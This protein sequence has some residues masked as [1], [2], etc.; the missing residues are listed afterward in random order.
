[1]VTSRRDPTERSPSCGVLAT[2]TKH[3]GS[4]VSAPVR[5]FENILRPKKSANWSRTQIKA[6]R[7]RCAKSW[8]LSSP[9]LPASLG[10]NYCIKFCFERSH[11]KGSAA[12]SLRYKLWVWPVIWS[13]TCPRRRS[14]P[15]VRVRCF[16]LTRDAFLWSESPLP[17]TW[18][19]WS[20]NMADPGAAILSLCSSDWGAELS[21]LSIMD[22]MTSEWPWPLTSNI[23]MSSFWSQSEC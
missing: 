18:P 22:I 19:K 9:W 7:R 3:H 4:F 2:E 15:R 13:Q 1:M 8:R 11:I 16:D 5:I 23:L 21:Q 14:E 17:A 20:Q 6:K 12:T 10:F